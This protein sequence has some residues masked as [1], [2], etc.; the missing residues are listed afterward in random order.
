MGSFEQSLSSCCLLLGRG[1]ERSNIY[2]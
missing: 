2:I 1:V